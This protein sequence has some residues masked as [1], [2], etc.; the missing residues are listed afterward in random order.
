M[1][2]LLERA[3]ELISKEDYAETIRVCRRGLLSYPGAT[4]LR[5]VLGLALVRAGRFEEARTELANAIHAN[6]RDRDAQR[7]LGEAL[8]GLGQRD[9]AIEAFRAALALD[10]TD[11]EAEQLLGEAMSNEPSSV[12]VL[13]R[14]FGP[15]NESPIDAAARA[16]TMVSSSRTTARP[17]PFSVPKMTEDAEDEADNA[18]TRA[19]SVRELSEVSPAELHPSEFEVF[20]PRPADLGKAPNP[21]EPPTKPGLDLN[22]VVLSATPEPPA[23]PPISQVTPPKIPKG[24]PAAP[25]KAVPAEPKLARIEDK[26]SATPRPAESARKASQPPTRAKRSRTRFIVTTIIV[27]LLLAVIGAGVVIF[28]ARSAERDRIA[29]LVRRAQHDARKTSLDAA[30]AAFNASVSERHRIELALLEG[31]SCLDFDKQRCRNAQQTLMR[32]DPSG[33]QSDEAII[34]SIYLALRAHD[35]KAVARFA[36][37]ANKASPNAELHFA[38]SLAAAV[39]GS[40]GEALAEAKQANKIDPQNPRY[41]ARSALLGEMTG[42]AGT[43]ISALNAAVAKESDQGALAILRSTRARVL[44]DSGADAAQAQRDADMVLTELAAQAT[45]SERA[46]AHWV[47]ASYALDAG[48]LAEAARFATGIMKDLAPDEELTLG[49]ADVL[50]RSGSIAEA[51][52]LIREPAPPVSINPDLRKVLEAELTFQRGEYV[53]AEKLLENIDSARANFIRGEIRRVQQR[54][55]EA[56]AFYRKA[57]SDPREVVR[58][59]IAIAWLRLEAHDVPGALVAIEPARAARA[60]DAMV[61]HVLVQAHLFAGD[62]AKAREVIERARQLNNSGVLALESAEVDLAEGKSPATV[63]NTLK[64]VHE[65]FASNAAYFKLLGRAETAA[66]TYDDA[67]R[68]YE[69]VLELNPADRE[70]HAALIENAFA[71]HDLVAA[72]TL[73]S[74]ATFQDDPMLQK[75]QLE[76]SLYDGAGEGALAAAEQA[77]KAREDASIWVLYGQLLYQAERNSDASK[78]FEHAV[79]LDAARGDAWLGR[80]FASI[81]KG[82]LGWAERSIDSAARSLENPAGPKYVREIDISAA[83]AR[84]RYEM[85]DFSG[86][87]RYARAAL[88][89]GTPPAQQPGEAHLALANLRVEMGNDPTNEL[90]AA[91][92]AEWPPTVEAWGRLAR[93]L[94]HGTDACTFG[95]RYLSA[96]PNGYDADSVRRIVAECPQ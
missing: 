30:L 91:A 75:H 77:A 3:K 47:K 10:P 95:K 55:A 49:V 86:S 69:R 72:R 1:N 27:G 73:L 24:P 85:G 12:A 68:S 76:L 14:W 18:P 79:S 90:R 57:A 37:S 23:P 54:A 36:K 64:A 56:E 78:A 20:T 89:Q 32:L 50:L 60:G 82:D 96:A 16:K 21:A 9:R 66:G 94:E 25:Q 58:A 13:D 17:G 67:K 42:E 28:G 81:R 2:E 34:A 70:A 63:V 6:P 5:L 26:P 35:Y 65:Q 38:L 7:W 92:S 87:E 31:L 46:V 88:Q 71:R 44:F 74:D 22:A 33:R 40:L 15:Q 41:L 52:T 61:V 84:L 11:K 19:I 93:Q 53:K 4:S 51:S 45:P 29:E 43:A 80:A 8:L 48:D 39:T 59:S 62:F 83:R